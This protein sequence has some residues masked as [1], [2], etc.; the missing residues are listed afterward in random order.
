MESIT[1]QTC[2]LGWR[3]DIPDHR[4]ISLH[5]QSII[6]LLV[7]IPSRHEGPRPQQSDLREYCPE[8][9]DQGRLNTGATCACLGLIQYY[10]RRAEGRM[11]SPSRLFTYKTSRRRLG[12]SGDT[13]TS[14]RETWKSIAKL[15]VVPEKDW[16][17]DIYKLD[18]EPDAYLYHCAEK[19]TTM[20]YVRLDR[21]DS[22]MTL[23]N[24]RAFLAAGFPCV[25]GFTVCTSLST[26]SE[27]RFPTSYDSVRG[28]QAVMAVGYDDGLSFY[29]SRGAL[30]IRNSWGTA[31][32]EDGYGWLPYDYVRGQLATD[33]WTVLAP[34]W[35]A[36][37]EFQ[38]PEYR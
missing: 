2:S 35:L 24:I 32:G 23:Q 20:R 11:L 29:S 27:I 7:D 9:T 6:K 28:G 19:F 30:L 15:G 1:T 14:L 37:G 31:W 38:R 34:D 18:D 22:E 5:D 36:T 26:G 33:F 16:P 4:D 13:G 12:W 10:V 8:I 21:G 3:R 25:F 17:Y